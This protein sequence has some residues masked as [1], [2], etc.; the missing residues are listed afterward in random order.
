MYWW[1]KKKME[2]FNW[3]SRYRAIIFEFFHYLTIDIKRFWR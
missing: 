3:F 2:H 1:K